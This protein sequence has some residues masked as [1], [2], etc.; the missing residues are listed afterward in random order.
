M[1]GLPADAPGVQKG[2]LSKVQKTLGGQGVPGFEVC[3]RWSG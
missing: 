2:E 1:E 3:V